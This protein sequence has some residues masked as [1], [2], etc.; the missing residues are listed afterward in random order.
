MRQNFPISKNLSNEEYIAQ[1]QQKQRMMRQN[2]ISVE[3]QQRLARQQREQG[4]N[5]NFSGANLDRIQ[6]Q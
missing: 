5:T 3:Q 6:Q 2:Q 1:Q 4:F